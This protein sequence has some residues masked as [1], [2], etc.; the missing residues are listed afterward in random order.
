[1]KVIC[2]HS[3]KGGV[4]KTTTALSI[5]SILA[6][7]DANTL[8]L[9]LDPQAAAT[10]HLA[11]ETSTE[12]DWDKTIRQV[13]IGEVP[14]E[15]TLIHPWP[16]LSFCPSQ[17]RLQN[18]EKDLA[19]ETNPVF[20]I[21]DLLDTIRKDFDYCVIDTAPNTGLLTKAALAASHQIIIPCLTEK[22]PIESLEI[23][24][25]AIDKISSAQKYLSTKIESV[26]ILPTFFEERR[27]LTEA[28]Y[29]ALKQGYSKYLSETVIHRSV[30]IGK[31][32]GQA[33]GRL[34]HSMR[35][36]D[37]YMHLIDEILGGK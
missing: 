34:E 8:M 32:Y 10:K 36:K 3:A 16:N 18:I 37:E 33:L 20:V 28:F 31:T 13:L 23:S 14:F 21:H 11:T 22:W 29:F 12:Y 19:D 15:E 4:G 1:M 17:L 6:E 35:A 25:E 9:D 30:D 5:A 26:R 24:I 2:I 7:Q 27:Q